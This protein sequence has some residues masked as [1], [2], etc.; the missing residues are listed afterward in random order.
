MISEQFNK[1][2]DLWFDFRKQVIYKNRYFIKH[3][4]LDYLEK[5]ADKN[6]RTVEENTL[7]F[8]A[9]RYTDSTV[10]IPYI[11][12]N[13]NDADNEVKDR[14][15]SA[16]QKAIVKDKE[17]SGFWGYDDNNSLVP[18]NADMVK[19]GRTNPAY[20]KYLYTATDPYTALVEVRPYLE[21]KVS[22]AELEV[23]DSLNIVD[24]SFDSDSLREH[25]GF[26]RHLIIAMMLEF[27][28]PSDGDS[29]SYIP[30]QYIAE[31]IKTLG[32]EGIKF[33]S[34]LNRSG[35]NVTIFNYDNKLRAKCSKLYEINDIC[36]EAKP[37]APK[38]EVYLRHPRLMSPMLKLP[39]K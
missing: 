15:F 34:S 29:K 5:F 4:V 12:D 16:M 27:S 28:E 36:Y 14:Y 8:R 3:E 33:N 1:A 17:E 38:N 24:F 11:D 13:H 37:I 18:P 22:I 19:D 21:S 7:L 10:F 23:V 6:K 20:I 35:K 25:E 32:F 26:D 31:F 30:T 2:F 39:R 9:R